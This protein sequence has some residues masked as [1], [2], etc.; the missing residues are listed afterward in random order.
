M[1]PSPIIFYYYIDL[2][3]TEA[4]CALLKQRFVQSGH[5]REIE[6]RCWNCYNE[7]PGRDGDVYCYD[8]LVLT[9]LADEGYI[10][11]LPDIIDTGRVFPWIL[12]RSRIRNKIYG[13][14]MLT[15]ANVLICREEDRLPVRNI[16]DLPAGL[17]APLKSMAMT[18]YLHALCNL[19][20]RKEEV[21]QTL[22]Q[23]QR[24]IGAEA[25]ATS[26][27]AV[28]D[29]VDRFRRG[30]CRY[31]I[32]FTEDIRHLDP[33]DY[34]VSLVNFSD[35]PVNEMPLLM[36][37]FVSLGTDIDTE[38]LLDCLDLMEIMADSDFVYDLCTTGGHLQYM[39]PA[40]A[41]VYPRLAQLDPI[42][43][44]FYQIVSNEDNGILRFG[45]HFYTDY[46]QKEEELLRTLEE[47]LGCDCEELRPAH[48]DTPQPPLP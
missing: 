35:Q 33:G 40:D 23:I 17:A 46:L 42:Y 13:I 8:A 19:Q 43:Q 4:F 7:P 2:A 11:V 44:D 47:A 14:P 5:D 15:C 12:D 36:T 3:D 29:G 1:N 20:D 48:R 28:Y 6:F 45:K 27:F 30:D 39:L 18:Y 10:R 41:T 32:G 16:Y 24:I 26:K 31:L 21:I 37:D 25:Y 34:T 38:K 22:R 9:T